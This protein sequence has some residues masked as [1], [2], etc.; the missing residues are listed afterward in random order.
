MKRAIGWFAANDVAA[1]LL[2][3]VI[4]IGGGLTVMTVKMGGISKW[5]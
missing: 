1:N 5:K 4:V 3:L 2:M